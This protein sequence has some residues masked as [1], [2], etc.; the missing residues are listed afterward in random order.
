MRGRKII[1]AV[2]RQ[3]EIH[4]LSSVIDD[5]EAQVTAGSLAPERFALTVSKIE[6]QRADLEAQPSTAERIDGPK[7]GQTFGQD[8]FR[9]WWKPSSATRP[10]GCRRRRRR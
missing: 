1:P 3:A 4:R 8:H 2:G 10:A 7:T 5:L 6:K 9:C